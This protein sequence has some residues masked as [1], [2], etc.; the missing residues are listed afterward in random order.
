MS[1]T[2]GC[3]CGAVRYTLSEEPTKIG[4]CHC[5]MC[6]RWS[7]GIYLASEAKPDG[8]AID[9]T[10]NLTVF[11]SSDWA[12]RGFCNKCG[13][14]L[15]YRV[16]APGPMHGVYHFGVGTLDDA[17]QAELNLELFI[18]QKPK[19]YSFAQNTNQMTQAEVE[20][21]FAKPSE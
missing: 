9:G 11:K 12:E 17:A 4:A 8:M 13:S 14:S 5:S 1:L 3:L 20:A 7:G 6:R 21:M 15:F 18:D 2:G 19:G 16:T 10:E